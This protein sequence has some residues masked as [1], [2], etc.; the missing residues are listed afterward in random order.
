M[1]KLLE[2]IKSPLLTTNESD[3]ITYVEK[4]NDELTDLN[5]NAES[6]IKATAEMKSLGDILA[7]IDPNIEK[8]SKKGKS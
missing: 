3:M 4:L 7:M 5:N 1:T 2:S 6:P 8:Y